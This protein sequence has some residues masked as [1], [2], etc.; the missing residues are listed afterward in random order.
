MNPYIPKNIDDAI[1]ATLAYFDI[2]DFPLK[3]NELKEYLYYENPKNIHELN[4]MTDEYITLKDRKLLIPQRE[5]R[6][7]LAKKLWKKTK[8]YAYFMKCVPFIKM[9]A[10]C[11]NLS[12]NNPSKTSDIDLFVICEKNRLYLGRTLFTFWLH[13]LGIR[14]H[15]KKISGR[16]C[17]SFFI[18]EEH[19]NLEDILLRNHDIYLAYWLKTLRPIFGKKNYM[20]LLEKN[21]HWLKKYFYEQTFHY[22]QIID[23]SLIFKIIQTSQEWFLNLTIAPFLEKLLKRWQQKRASKKALKLNQSF[24]NVIISD[25]MLKFHDQDRRK[26]IQ[27]S[28]LKK[29]RH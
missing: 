19:M 8:R 16:F 24:P 3:K 23:H 1:I 21:K 25:T 13:V 9:V 26:I 4:S 11:N 7:K 17:L 20:R 18:T 2:F 5:K 15:H 28:W 14:R 29:W 27:K 12:Y 22:D 10:V 6:E